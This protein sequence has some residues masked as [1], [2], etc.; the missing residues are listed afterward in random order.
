MKKVLIVLAAIIA[1]LI[2]VPF[3]I[4]ADSIRAKVEQAAS[5]AAGMKVTLGGLHLKVLPLPGVSISDLA[6]YDVPGGTPRVTVGSGSVSVEV[7]PLFSGQVEMNGIRFSDIRLRVSDK[8]KGKEVH[9]VLIDHV[10]GKVR[11]D[12]DAGKLMLPDWS[13]QLYRGKVDLDA[14]IAPLEGKQRII[15]ATV[16]A[17]GI[18][19]QPLVTDASG[20]KRMSGT[21]NST[22]KISARGEDSQ[23]IERSLKVDGPVKLANGQFYGVS[24][25]GIA[26][27][28]IPGSTSS[29]DIAYDNMDTQLTVRGK[30]IRA[31]DI[32]LTSDVLDAKGKVHI[33]ADKKLDGDV[34]VTSKS[35]L[36][37]AK[38]LVGGTTDTPLIY[39]APSSMIG[40]V[41]GGSV[42]GTTGAAIGSKIGGSVG[43]V[44]EGVGGLLGGGSNKK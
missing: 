1:I 4:P 22:M 35:G 17:A 44:L 42:G 30:D 39:P 15:T 19:M 3:L 24:L 18:Q 21:L 36:S 40:G 8:A 6:V 20:Q 33:A 38:L 25:K 26:S 13:A 14:E 37:G 2:I 29:G 5:E 34:T 16:K 28:L 41:I 7:M 12:T 31:D 43:S 32:A 11:L 10:A 9:T 23:A 27:M